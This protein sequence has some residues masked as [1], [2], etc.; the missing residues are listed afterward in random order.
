MPVELVASPPAGMELPMVGASELHDCRQPRPNVQLKDC[1]LLLPAGTATQS[2][3]DFMKAAV[4]RDTNQHLVHH[5]HHVRMTSFPRYRSQ[6]LAMQAARKSRG[7]P[8]RSTTKYNPVHMFWAEEIPQCFV[9][10][11]R[12]PAARLASGLRFLQTGNG[13]GTGVQAWPARPQPWLFRDLTSFVAAFRDQRHQGHRFAQQLYWSSVSMNAQ[14]KPTQWDQVVGGNNFLA[15]QLDYLRGWRERCGTG[16]SELHFVCTERF[17]QDSRALLRRFS[18]QG[19]LMAPIH[20][21]RRFSGNDTGRSGG[22]EAQQRE[23]AQQSIAELKAAEYVR[24][25][26]YPWDAELHRHLCGDGRQNDSATSRTPAAVAASTQQRT[27]RP[28][29]ATLHPRPLHE[30]GTTALSADLRYTAN[31][32]GLVRIVRDVRSWWQAH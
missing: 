20:S 1:A 27:P 9:M 29:A 10:S 32:A 17:A 2:L 5:L 3:Y 24:Q 6:V 19:K 8:N 21:N 22:S 31:E 7:S 14:V 30:R 4:G 28:G 16:S 18:L 23:R 26:M 12:D 13:L 11:V 25:V 15:S